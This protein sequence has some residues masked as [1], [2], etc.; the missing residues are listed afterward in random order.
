MKNK[1]LS[2]IIGMGIGEKHLIALNKNKNSIVKYGCDFNNQKIT[3]LKSKY[4]K[5]KIVKNE[6]E[7]FKDKNIDLVSI[8]SYD[9]YHFRQVLKA[10]K[11][12]K[13]IIIEKP[14]CLTEKEFKI[15]K[16][17][18]YSNPK[19][20]ITS[21]LVL[22][23]LDIFTKLKKKINKKTIQK[24]YYIEADY[25]WGR[26][27][28]L[29][30]WRS[31]IKNYSLIFGA[32]IHMIDLVMWLVNDRPVD[33]TAYGNN[34]VTKN[35]SFKKNSFIIIVLKFANGM[36]SKITGDGVC[37]YPHFH[38]IKLYSKNR[39]II[40]SYKNSFELTNKNMKL[41]KLKGIYPDKKSRKKIIDS[42]VNSLCDN[43]IKPIVSK[44]DMLDLM[45]V[46]IAAEKSL[47]SSKSIK[48][49]Y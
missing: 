24:P 36:I 37:V 14:L 34:I 6:N 1:I 12:N 29:F 15:I 27:H 39:S 47:K 26:K 46:C 45:T 31:K 41:K 21:N 44:K 16:K 9:N 18:L 43:K 20:K 5:I 11:F 25:L 2:G 8:A 49:K 28:K 30:G 33:V 40:H 48:I 42:F 4:P 7:I 3:Y 13:N 38:E 23:T 17:K 22:R 32:A 35:S 10:I 19:I